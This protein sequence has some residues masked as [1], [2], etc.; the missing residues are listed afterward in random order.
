MDGRHTELA[1]IAVDLG[2]DELE[3]DRGRAR[4]WRLP[5]RRQQPNFFA[6]FAADGLSEL[7]TYLAQWA[8]HDDYQGRR[9]RGKP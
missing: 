3:G 2:L 9:T 4:W 8:A 6:S 1:R 5:F 7:E